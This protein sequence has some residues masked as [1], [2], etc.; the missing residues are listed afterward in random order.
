MFLV[1]CNAFSE[2]YEDMSELREPYEI[3]FANISSLS[4]KTVKASH[5]YRLND[6]QMIYYV[7]E[8]LESGGDKFYNEIFGYFLYDSSKVNFIEDGYE[9]ISKEKVKKLME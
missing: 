3:T 7:P 5:S 6:E 9:E 8:I 1:G 2:P 4:T